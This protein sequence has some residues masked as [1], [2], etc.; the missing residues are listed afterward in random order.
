MAARAT[1]FLQ[2]SPSTLTLAEYADKLNTQVKPEDAKAGGVGRRSSGRTSRTRWRG[3]LSLYAGV[4]ADAPPPKLEQKY[5]DEA[6]PV[7]E[8]QLERGGLRLAEV[9]NAELSMTTAPTARSQE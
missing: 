1:R 9:L 3:T 8:Q 2:R 4:S 6:R 5:V 7:V